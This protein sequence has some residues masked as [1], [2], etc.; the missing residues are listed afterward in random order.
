[1]NTSICITVLNEESSI[2]KLL[3]SLL[4]Q[5]QKPTEIVI[6]DGGSIDKTVDIIRHYQKKY[7]VIKLIIE[8]SSR[9]KARNIAVDI[10]KNEIVAMTDAGCIAD[11]DWL[12][13]I[14]HPFT[15]T[16]RVDVVAGFYKM[17]GGTNLQKAESIFMGVTPRKFDHN[18][19]PSTRS[20]AFTKKIWEE[21]GGFPENLNGTAEDTVFNK[22][23]V[24]NKAIISRV[25]V[26]TVEWGMPPTISRFIVSIFNYA[27]GDVKSKVWV[28]PGK[29]IMSHNIKSLFILL[30]YLIGITLLFFSFKTPLL[31][32]SLLILFFVYLI[33]SFR[34]IYIEFGDWKVA[35][36]GPLLQITSD[37]A[38]I[39]GAFCG[40]LN[41]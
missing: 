33:W 35:F 21:V 40:I 27:K 18:F 13:N 23:L 24:E 22:K 2:E 25:K 26:A 29:G 41:V 37:L 36:W 31:L 10:A 17:I 11:P 6:V 39:S 32:A 5:S 4:V 1:M 20:I 9:A 30:R 15:S 3:D 8:N 16:P 12:K 28:F 7:S 38:V 19:L 14:T 34:K